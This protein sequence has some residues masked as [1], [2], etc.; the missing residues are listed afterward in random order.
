MLTLERLKSL[1]SYNPETGMFI[2]LARPY[3]HS[4]CKAGD[5]A[6]NFGSGGAITI[7]LDKEIYRLDLLA[8]FY[9]TGVMPKCVE[10][11]DG[12]IS[13]NR[14]SNLTVC[15]KKKRMMT[16][17]ARIAESDAFRSHCY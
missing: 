13:N 15:S 9:M 12:I 10:H 14:Y 6:G 8:I 4:K 11:L 2:W 5:V 17:K 16:I 3:A 7:G 1:L